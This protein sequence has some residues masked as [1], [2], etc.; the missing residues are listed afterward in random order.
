MSGLRKNS[1]N[2]VRK[3]IAATAHPPAKGD[4]VWDGIDEDE[5]PLN[6]DEMREGM[7]KPM[8]RP[9]SDNPKVSTTIRLS[10]EVVEYFK[11]SGKG[12]QTRIDEA[13]KEYVA[14]RR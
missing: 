11:T 7:R 8:G 14:A 12:W 4:F 2:S 3:A 5:R 13:L 10:A 6:K 9:K 1:A